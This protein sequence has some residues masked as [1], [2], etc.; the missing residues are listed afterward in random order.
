MDGQ[1]NYILTTENYLY[2][3]GAY[4]MAGGVQTNALARW[5]GEQ[6]CRYGWSDNYWYFAILLFF[7]S[8]I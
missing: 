1:A 8:V 5:D 2:A 4:T 7:R 6:W 3:A